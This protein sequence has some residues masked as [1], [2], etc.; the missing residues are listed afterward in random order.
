MKAQ[1]QK[2]RAAAALAMG[3][4]DTGCRW[5]FVE[6]AQVERSRRSDRRESSMTCEQ[7]KYPMPQCSSCPRFYCANP[8][9][10]R[11]HDDADLL[12]DGGWFPRDAFLAPG[13]CEECA[14]RLGPVRPEKPTA[15]EPCDR[16]ESPEGRYCLVLSET[17]ADALEPSRRWAAQVVAEA[18][19][20]K[21]CAKETAAKFGVRFE[22]R[23]ASWA[24]RSR[25][26]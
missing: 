24:P 23:L 6:L 7:C 14:R 17:E 9:C 18:P 5:K 4:L 11:Y 20:C 15:G 21:R 13:E 26:C 16:C 3:M 19:L 10:G 25:G 22:E 8:D 1:E 2:Y 12:Y